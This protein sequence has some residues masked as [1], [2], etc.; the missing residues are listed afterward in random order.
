[1][2]KSLRFPI[3]AI[4]AWAI[5]L[6]FAG[7]ASAVGPTVGTPSVESISY[8]TA[9]VKADF[10]PGDEQGYYTTFEVAELPSE[11]WPGCFGFENYF[12]AGSGDVTVERELSGLNAGRE[13]AVRLCALG[14]DFTT[15][16]RS[17]DPNPTFT[18]LA[19]SPPAV[20]I[21]PITSFT[22]TTA[23]FSG[24]ID[25]EASIIDPGFEV[26]WHFECTPACPSVEN[27]HNENGTAYTLPA[28]SDPHEVKVD[29]TDLDPNTSYDVRLVAKNAG[30]PSIAGPEQF[31]TDPAPPIVQAL[32]AGPLETNSAVLAAKVN[33]RKG[34]T[35]YRFEWGPDTS[36]GDDT[37][38]ELVVPASNDFEIVTA[39][40]S[41]LTPGTEYHFRVVAENTETSVSTIGEDHAFTTL[42]PVPA[43]QACGNEELRVENDSTRL[44]DCR[45]YEMVSPVEK[46]GSEAIAGSSAGG[47][48][49]SRAAASGN[50]VSYLTYLP[51]AGAESAPLVSRYRS[52]RSATGWATESV[53][54][55]FELGERVGMDVPFFEFD[56][57]LTKG[58]LLGYGALNPGDPA[59]RFNL[60][61]ADFDNHTYELM[62]TPGVPLE[63]TGALSTEIPQFI[64]A[65]KSFTHFIFGSP[66]RLTADSP[67]EFATY[68]DNL[69]EYHQGDLTYLARTPDPD[70]AGPETEEPFAGGGY[71]PAGG[72]H[73]GGTA[74]AGKIFY[75]NVA[76]N[77]ISRD[78]SKL[79]F[80][81]L[82][83]ACGGAPN[84]ISV[85]LRDGGVVT[86]IAGTQ[87]TVP[88]PDGSKMKI[89]QGASA[90][91]DIAFFTSEEK[92]TDGP[93]PERLDDGLSRE[94]LYRY[95]VASG[96]LEDITT[97]DPR[98]ASVLGVIAVND[99]GTRLYFA[100]QGALAPG[101]VRGRPNLYFWEEGVGTKLVATLGANSPCG[102]GDETIWTEWKLGS[103]F[104]RDSRVSSDLSKLVIASTEQL[105]GY[106]TNGTRQIYLYDVEAGD[107][108]GSLACVSCN[109][110][111][112]G[113]SAGTT[114]WGVRR[115]GSYHP[116]WLTRLLSDD[117][118]QIVFE[119]DE[120]LVTTDT[121]GLTDVYRWRDGRVALLSTGR[122]GRPS[123]L[124]EL[125]A[126]GDDVF[127]ATTENLGEG[128]KDGVYDVYDVRVGGGFPRSIPAPACEGDSC[129][130]PPNIPND[131]TPG[132][133]S[134]SGP[135]DPS[136]N[137]QRAARKK[138][139]KGKVRKQGKC[140]KKRS[141]RR[142]GGHKK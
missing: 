110:R 7:I 11:D 21:D 114:L 23:H 95:D 103:C 36:Y 17:S 25:P 18:T 100:A 131:P 88:D 90:D 8:T 82:P 76:P 63:P 56:E 12:P 68:P 5:S 41:G 84:C 39:P 19:V 22:A 98:G 30:D 87:R 120:A 40:I 89:F 118:K 142:Q 121:N 62:S 115:G 123:Y 16:A 28:D 73:V 127:I 13:Y 119:S 49:E 81:L 74:G 38:A 128:D 99:A 45:A 65:D 116:A 47:V 64:A 4:C 34:N 129:L 20:S 135:A 61:L 55:P 15:E 48:N 136:P 105:T 77:F 29:A 54:P 78:A 112:Q 108:S 92:L 107:G 72:D 124:A 104:G 43:P 9:T 51:F 132:S 52:V 125:S 3:A 83:T 69:Y 58:V 91:G 109:R 37:T 96:D 106:D 102:N 70:G 117:A 94:I 79:F 86:E 53:Q 101:A 24:T 32:Y 130:A 57:E 140:V 93:L 97:A 44:P 122:S 67:S 134:H 85:F 33:P 60:Y 137:A 138:C 6:L 71:I 113:S 139:R 75:F 46:E 31:K 26:T 1:V 27:L 10:N 111:V 80:S 59:A 14:E 66:M 35:T 50:A 141:N 42:E 126:S 133:A 2:R